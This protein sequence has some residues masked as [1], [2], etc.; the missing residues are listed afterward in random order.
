M[1]TVHHLNNSRSQ[2]ILWL[3]EELGLDYEIRKYERDP[4]TLLAPP[5]LRAVHPLGKAPVIEDGGI[6][7]AESGAIVDYL[8]GRYGPQLAPPPGTPERLRYTQF[9]HY[10]EGSLMPPLLLKL[11]FDRVASSPA[12][13]FVRPIARAIADK[14]KSGFVL[15]QIRQHLD[16]LEGELAARDWFAGDAF[17]AADIQMSF[18]LEA[19]AARAG[20][21]D[22]H[23]RLADFLRRIHARPA[24]ARALERG[25]PFDLV[26]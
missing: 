2:R 9:L 18:P 20:L 4:K 16:Y 25:G 26:K 13:F 17:S 5:A 10:A 6:V 8:V 11:V 14:V 23:P 12:P 24:Y 19:A 21:G 15:P 7:V 1:I 22:G 3:L